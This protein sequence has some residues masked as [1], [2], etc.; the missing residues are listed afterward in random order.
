MA[1]RN[2]AAFTLN[3]Y[4]EGVLDFHIAE[5]PVF[6]DHLTSRDKAELL[7]QADGKPVMKII[8]RDLG[9]SQEDIDEVLAEEAQ[10]TADAVRGL[11]DAAFAG[12]QQDM[13]SQD[14][15]AQDAQAQDAAQQDMNAQM[16]GKNADTQTPDA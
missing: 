7:M 10:R 14:P 8:M 13:Q 3:S 6:K 9:Y 5:R 16:G 2:F 1:T 11:A 15:H 4:D 12:N